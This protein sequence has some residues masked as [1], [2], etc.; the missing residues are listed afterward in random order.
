MPKCFK[1]PV[2]SVYL[3]DKDK[4]AE[5]DIVHYEFQNSHASALNE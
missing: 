5:L 1:E 2:E 4:S 3:K